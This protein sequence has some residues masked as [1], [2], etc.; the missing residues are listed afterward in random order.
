MTRKDVPA[1][2][3]SMRELTQ[4]ECYQRLGAADVGRVA[5]CTE[6]GPTIIPVN[7]MVDGESIIVRTAPYTT[8]ADH[9]LGLMAF[10]VDQLEPALKF[11][12]SVLVV[13]RAMPVEDVDESTELRSSGRLATWAPGARNLFIRLT[14][15][16]VTGREIG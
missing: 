10:E 2:A 13:G 1:A 16:Q 14:P 4:A 8:L 15:R 5:L 6:H 7:Y 9:A 11:G 12:W 3:G